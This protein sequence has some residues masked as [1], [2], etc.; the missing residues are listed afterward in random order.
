MSNS[1]IEKVD[2]RVFE[3][4]FGQ[5]VVVSMDDDAWVQFDWAV[6]QGWPMEDW[7]ME[8][9]AIREPQYSLGERISGELWRLICTRYKHGYD[10]PEPTPPHDY[11]GFLQAVQAGEIEESYIETDD[12]STHED[13]VSRPLPLFSGAVEIV[14]MPRKYWLHIE[15]LVQIGTNFRSW[16]NEE[17][18]KR[19]ETEPNK[20]LSDYLKD[21]L[22]QSEERHFLRN[23]DIPLFINP[24]GYQKP[25]FKVW[26]SARFINQN[27]SERSVMNALGE[28]ETVSLSKKHW[29]HFDWLAQSK[30]QD[31]DKWTSKIDIGRHK[32]DGFNVT[33][34]GYLEMQLVQDE[35]RRHQAGEVV[36]LF[37]NPER[38]I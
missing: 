32:Y 38:P 4:C 8:L 37:I 29:Q 28:Q 22:S 5:D 34:E 13:V 10:C 19:L 35:S 23:S 12:V 2:N 7:V 21:A 16:A 20:S 11:E 27:Y 18:E 26:D 24:E 30:K 9:D 1:E 17:N 36:P 31:M 15:F 3:N 33:F 14:E 25:S 6:G